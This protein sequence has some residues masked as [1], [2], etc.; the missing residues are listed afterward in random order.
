MPATISTSPPASCPDGLPHEQGTAVAANFQ[1]L[2]LDAPSQSEDRQRTKPVHEDLARKQRASTSFEPLLCIKAAA[3]AAGL[4]Y[5]LLQ[6]AVNNGDI[7][8][9]QFGNKRR[10]VRLSDIEAAIIKSGRCA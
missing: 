1:S 8:T 5:W 3:D 10:R 7:P 4:K 9:Y 6:R 2:N